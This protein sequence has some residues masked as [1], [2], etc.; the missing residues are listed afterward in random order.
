TITD[1]EK[2]IEELH[3]VRE[4]G[5][6]VDREENTLGLRC[7]GVAISYRT[8]ARDASSCSMPVARLTPAHEQLVKDALFDARDRLT[9]ATRRLRPGDSALRPGHARDLPVSYPPLNDPGALRMAGI[10]PG[11]PAA[12][13]RFHAHWARI[14]GS[15]EI[16]ARTVPGDGD[17]VGNAAVYGEAGEREVTYWVD[18]AYW[19]RG[20][21]TA[22]LRAL[23][24]EVD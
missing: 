3:Q 10:T 23:L 5:F 17:V 6:A 8:P 13:D 11:H 7:F 2:L 14:L 19:G 24:A 15:P 4:Q 9:L 1:R 18:R 16:A 12:R 22:A 20:I 21:A